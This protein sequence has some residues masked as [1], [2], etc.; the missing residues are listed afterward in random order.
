M[1]WEDWEVSHIT[2]KRI[3]YHQ[4]I[5]KWNCSS[6]CSGRHS[7][8]TCRDLQCQQVP[9]VDGTWPHRP[10]CRR[11]AHP[12]TN[13]CRKGISNETTREGYCVDVFSVIIFSSWIWRLKIEVAR[14]IYSYLSHVQTL[15]W[16]MSQ[17]IKAII[18]F[19]S[20]AEPP[21]SASNT[22]EEREE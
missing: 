4:N 11:K 10:H 1:K 8:G 19:S 3:H 18:F 20:S 14:P 12:H 9:M 21:N 13:S 6:C 17:D 2:W 22:I 7:T 16:Q 5:C 15:G